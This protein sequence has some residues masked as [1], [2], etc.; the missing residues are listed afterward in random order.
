MTSQ[1]ISEWGFE[2]AFIACEQC[3]WSY[4]IPESALPASADAPIRCPHCYTGHL[5]LLDK[6]HEALDQELPQLSPLELL[7]PFRLE[8]E[9]LAGQI[10]SFSKGIPFAP[11]DLNPQMLA[12]RL[13]RVY[14]PQ[15]LVDVGV[16]ADWQMEAGFDYQ[17][18]S[19]QERYSDKGGGWTTREVK[20]TRIRWEPRQGNLDRSYPNRTAPALE[21]HDRLRG[22]LGDFELTTA[23]TYKSQKAQEAFV[24]L[25][26]RDQ[27]NAW[28]E[29]IPGLQAAAARDCQQ[30]AGAD[31]Q[32]DFRWQ[33]DYHSQNWTLLLRP[34]FTS[35]YLDDQNQPQP[36]IINGQTGRISGRRRASLKRAQRTSLLVLGAAV[37]LFLFSV[38]FLLGGIALPVLVP[39]GGIGLLVALLVGLGAII[40]PALVWQF[41]RSKGSASG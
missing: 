12:S 7:L 23:Q 14:L 32:R 29:V 33:P 15:W 11:A 22:Q 2:P 13:K 16:T 10:Q 26:D 36:V 5:S 19:H 4:L 40:P 34:V 8:A 24:R 39:L 41:N 18:V 30:A 35:Y 1:G 31:H 21:T 25:P 6:N 38:I 27:T 9:K 37:V 20:E 3:G 17:V 28:S